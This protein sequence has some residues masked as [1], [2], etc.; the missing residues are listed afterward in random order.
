MILSPEM[1]EA[2]ARATDVP[3]TRTGRI[4]ASVRGRVRP[5]DP[6]FW[7]VGRLMVAPDLQGRGLGRELLALGDEFHLR[8]DVTGPGLFE[9]RDGLQH[10]L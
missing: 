10:L 1:M 9:L 6:T 8:G 7:E 4:V 2:L 3:P 5:A